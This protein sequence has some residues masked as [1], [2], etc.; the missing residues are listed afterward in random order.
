LIGTVA[1]AGALFEQGAI[2]HAALLLSSF[3]LAPTLLGMLAGIG[4][5]QRISQDL[6]RRFVAL[7]FLILGGNLVYANW[8]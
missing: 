7:F 3:A 2:D 5:R 6:F 1:W 8:F 4:L